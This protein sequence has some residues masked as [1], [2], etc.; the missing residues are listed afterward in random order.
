LILVASLDSRT[1]ESRVKT[2]ASP[3][4]SLVIS[5]SEPQQSSSVVF[6]FNLLLPICQ[7]TFTPVL[8]LQIAFINILVLLDSGGYGGE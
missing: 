3:Y 1:Q 2:E 8:L 5:S 6:S 7:R 4:F